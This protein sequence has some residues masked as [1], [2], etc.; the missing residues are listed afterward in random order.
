MDYVYWYEEKYVGTK[1]GLRVGDSIVAV[2]IREAYTEDDREFKE[3]I[4]IRLEGSGI[5][6]WVFVTDERIVWKLPET[7]RLYLDSTGRLFRVVRQLQHQWRYGFRNNMA[8]AEYMVGGDWSAESNDN[9]LDDMYKDRQS[10]RDTLLSPVFGVSDGK[11]Y[12]P[13]DMIG[14]YRNGGVLLLEEYA[15]EYLQQLTN[16]GVTVYAYV[17]PTS[18]NSEIPDLYRGGSGT[19]ERPTSEWDAVLGL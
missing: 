11:V 7:N 14:F 2:S 6:E 18:D 12:T 13:S 8:Y 10:G 17:K 9:M 19:R 4:T 3:D 15:A 16:E 5:D 1:V